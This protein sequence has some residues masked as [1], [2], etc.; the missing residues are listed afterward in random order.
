MNNYMEKI[1]VCR[2]C[3]DSRI[4]SFFDLGLQPL[5]NSLLERVDDR[6]EAYPLSLCWCENC[7]LVQLEF[8]VDPKILFS[9]YVWVT[10]TSGVAQ[11][12]SKRFYEGLIQRTENSKSGYVLEIA[13]NDGT[14]LKP[15]LGNG[16]DVLG[17]DP[18]ENIV[19]MAEKD[20]VQTRFAFWSHAT[21]ED[22]VRERGKAKMIF[23]RNVLPH[24][25]NTRDFVDGLRE[26]LSDDGTLAIEA[27]HAKIILEG[28][29]Y[30]SIY[31]EHLCYFTFKSLENLLND[32]G[33]FVFDIAESPISG[34]S[35]IVYATKTKKEESAAVHQ[36]RKTEE[37]GATNTL[38]AWK[39]FAEKSF[40]HKDQFLKILNSYAE[41]GEVVYGWG[42]SARSSTMLNFCGIGAKLVKEIV[43]MNPLKHGRFTA[44]TRIPILSAE[45]VMK[46]GP[47]HICILAW[48]FTD[49]I[50][51]VLKSRFDYGGDYIIPLPGVPR[52]DQS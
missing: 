14:F 25:A 41:K 8:T 16:Y 37:A 13:S 1:S 17:V 6:E 5:A 9:K 22:V 28:L 18:A 51:S 48:N 21:A 12:F 36:Y 43:D 26:A 52:V 19:L 24:V 34:G 20:G 35:M 50:K 7:N 44:G 3:G 30:D 15:F 32:F 27:H 31:H 29:H 38:D 33:L 39:S 4:R 11:D 40:V 42:A 10:G 2:V 46:E 49:E 47:K 23:A 45:E